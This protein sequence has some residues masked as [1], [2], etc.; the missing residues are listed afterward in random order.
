MPIFSYL[1]FFNPFTRWWLFS[2]IIKM[3]V[4]WSCTV[5][6]SLCRVLPGN[7]LPDSR[8]VNN[9][10]DKALSTAFGLFEACCCQEALGT[11]AVIMVHAPHI[12]LSLFYVLSFKLSLLKESVFCHNIHLWIY[13]PFPS[14]FSTIC[15]V[16]Q[17]YNQNL[18]FK[19]LYFFCYCVSVFAC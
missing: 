1:Y 9:F 14:P 7:H 8:V 17:L 5:L 11:C 3:E 13:V 18:P 10:L 2:L 15:R 19:N 6:G 4:A 16:L 12:C